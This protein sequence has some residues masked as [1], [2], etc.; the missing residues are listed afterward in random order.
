ATRIPPNTAIVSS[1]SQKLFMSSQ[2]AHWRSSQT[3]HWRSSQT[4]HWR[5]S[6]TAHWRSSQTAH[7]R[8][9]QTAHWRSS[10]LAHWRSSQTAHWRSSRT[11]HWRS[12]RTAHWRS[13]RTAHWRSSQSEMIPLMLTA[14][15]GGGDSM[16]RRLARS[17]RVR[18]SFCGIGDDMS[19][20]VR[21]AAVVLMASAL[22]LQ[23]SE[24]SVVA[25][26]VTAQP[27]AARPPVAHP[28]LSQQQ[29]APADSSLLNLDFIFTYGART[30]GPIQWRDDA[31]GYLVL[32]P[33]AAGK[34]AVDIVSYDA[35]SGQKSIAVAAE[36][37]K[38]EGAASPIGV[39][40]FDF[41]AD[42]SKLLIFANSARVWRSNTR[43]DYWVLDLTNWRLKKLGGD[44]K[45]STLM[46]AKFSPDGRSVG[47]VRDNNIFVE[48]LSDNHITQLTTDGTTHLVNGTFDWVYEEE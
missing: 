28:S 24:L 44:A 18:L 47:Y 41:S 15:E 16:F 10:R 30:L 5:S 31:K 27:P 29:Q 46:F 40:Q 8:S 7:W 12:S 36:K 6:Q 13:S 33:S 3:A 4:A 45:P 9:S 1:V 37:L 23:A 38:P 39:E 21:L 48:D 17:L 14:S 19:K 43:G 42:G 32:E 22:A 35:A 20:R 11:A 25:G 34:G 26:P 2:T